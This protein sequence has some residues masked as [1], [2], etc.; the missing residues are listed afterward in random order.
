MNLQDWKDLTWCVSLSGA[1]LTTMLLCHATAALVI[2][3]LGMM[4][5]WA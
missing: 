3:L 1:L 2:R 4:F 5:G